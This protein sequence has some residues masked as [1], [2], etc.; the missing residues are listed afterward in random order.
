MS[1]RAVWFNCSFPF[2]STLKPLAAT[3]PLHETSIVGVARCCGGFVGCGDGVGFIVGE[4]VGAIVGVG[5]G[6]GVRVGVGVGVGVLVGDGV[7]VIVGV[8]VE[9]GIGLGVGVGVVL[10]S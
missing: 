2:I 3:V 10:F 6:V 8:G 9:V 5:V 4:A 7:G 1:G